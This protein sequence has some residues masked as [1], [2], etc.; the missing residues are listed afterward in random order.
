MTNLIGLVRGNYHPFTAFILL[1]S[2]GCGSTSPST[3]APTEEVPASVTS[4]A[5]E[6]PRTVGDYEH[7]VIPVPDAFRT[8]HGGPNNSDNLWI[9][10]APRME[11]DW[12]AESS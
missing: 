5:P 9:A 11:L 7:D 6:G 3:G 4:W 1:A 10:L 2:I 8:M 12:V